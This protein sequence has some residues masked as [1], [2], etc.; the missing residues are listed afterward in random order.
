ME[1]LTEIVREI[2]S[3][4]AILITSAISLT[5]VLEGDLTDEQRRRYELSLKRPTTV[6]Q[7]LD[8]RV[9]EVAGE[10]RSYYRQ[11][12]IKLKSPDAVHLATALMLKV[13]ELHTFDQGL[14][15]FNGDLMGH[16]I[17]ICKPKP[18]QLSLG[19]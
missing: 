1:G 11:K 18:G 7:N 9:S 19:L 14:L 12:G 17:K 8:R 5:E 13:D 4:K 6:I 15:R 2:D 16:N 3:K 10:V